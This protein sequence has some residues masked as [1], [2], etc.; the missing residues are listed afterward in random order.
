MADSPELVTC[1]LPVSTRISRLTCFQEGP[2]SYPN[3]GT[4]VFSVLSLTIRKPGWSFALDVWFGRLPSS[5]FPILL[6]WAPSHMQFAITYFTQLIRR[7][8]QMEQTSKQDPLT[9]WKSAMV[10]PVPKP[11]KNTICSG[12]HRPIRLLSTFSKLLERVEA[13]RLNSFIHQNHILPPEQFGFCKQ[14]S[15][16]C[17]IAQLTDPLF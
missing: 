12:S 11:E 6:S 5:V 10:I 17:Q 7:P 9:G 13:H 15:T 1:Y 4:E 2:G 3:E 14:L 8:I 16:V